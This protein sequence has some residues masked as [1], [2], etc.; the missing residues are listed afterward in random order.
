M[1]VAASGSLAAQPYWRPLERPT[2]H[3]LRAV[4]FTDSLRGWV[5]GDSGVILSTSDGGGSWAL[6]RGADSV[7]VT[8][9]FTIDSLRGWASAIRPLVDPGDWN[10]S[11]LYRTTDGGASWTERSLP[12]TFLNT[13]WFHDSL[14]G[15]AG[16]ELGL[17]MRTT[18]GGATWLESNIPVTV[19]STFPVKR[20][21]FRTP[22]HGYAVGGY[23]ESAGVIW[24]TVDGGANWTITGLGDAL[25]GIHFVDSL[26]VV[27]AGGGFDDG[28]CVTRT[29]NGGASWSFSYVGP[30]GFGTS[31]AART[32]GE[33][34]VPLGFAGTT[35][36]TFDS[37][38][39]W[40]AEANPGTIPSYGVAFPGPRHGYLVGDSG[41]VL[42][43]NPPIEIGV[44]SGWNIVSV[45][46]VTEGAI[47][48]SLFPGAASS[49]Y[50]YGPGGYAVAD[51]L[52]PGR[53]YWLKFTE[54]TSFVFTGSPRE[55]DTVMVSAGWNLV[56]TPSVPFDAS[57][58][59]TEPPGLLA[60]SF[61][62][63]A[64]GYLPAATLL[65]GKGYWVKAS[66]GGMLI[67]GDSE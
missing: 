36:A 50:A 4:W 44:G 63:F 46:L 61:Y 39:T 34:W 15:I 22:E 53:G 13:L 45:P 16:G 64:A 33:W 28:A 38:A 29:S 7:T 9:I 27:F 17:L 52:R 25:R 6:Q 26:T 12:D 30:F 35:M 54:P 14:N 8:D 31:M 47:G 51:T 66:A 20:I 65:P 49:A 18:D 23:P 1:L 21:A 19:Y 58:A 24:R 11:L 56:G 60:S 48:D 3:D 2:L 57:A 67:F 41:T 10:G 62:E 40:T 5:G 37:G 32:A 42:A 55:A 59:V 43:Y